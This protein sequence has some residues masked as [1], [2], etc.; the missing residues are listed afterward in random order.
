[1]STTNTIHINTDGPNPPTEIQ[2]TIR[3]DTHGD[4][5]KPQP[6]PTP[7][8]DPKPGPGPTPLPTP[9]PIPEPMPEPHPGPK[10]HP[11][12]GPKPEPEPDPELDDPQSQKTTISNVDIT[13]HGPKPP[14]DIQVTVTCDITN[15]GGHIPH[16]LFP[17]QGVGIPMSNTH[18]DTW[19]VSDTQ[20]YGR[21]E[22]V[23]TITCNGV[24][25]RQKF[26]A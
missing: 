23:L 18:G 13:T 9:Q 22:K 21:G 1:M 14:A 5:K 19:T 20:M 15:T 7:A 2:I 12:P 25:A 4:D 3:C 16:V 17:A 10:P 26:K 6:T 11:I 24:N 8:P